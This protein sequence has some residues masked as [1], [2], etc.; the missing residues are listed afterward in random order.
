M[1]RAFTVAVFVMG[2]GLGALVHQR[3]SSHVIPC[4]RGPLAWYD[5]GEKSGLFYEWTVG[6]C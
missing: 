4:Q 2:F 1:T 6:A 3:W 5:D